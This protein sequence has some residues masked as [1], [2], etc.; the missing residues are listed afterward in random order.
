MK[1]ILLP[2]LILIAVFSKADAQLL[3]ASDSVPVRVSYF[4]VEQNS[5]KVLLNWKVVCYLRFAD[6]EVQRSTN[7]TDYTTIN[8]FTADRIR[9]LSPFNLEDKTAAGRVYYRLKVGD[10]DGNFSTSKVLVTFGREKSFE[11]NSIT[12]SLITNNTLI[13]ISSAENDKADISI[14]NMQGYTVKRLTTN[15]NKGTTDIN[16]DVS[17]LFKGIYIIRVKNSFSDFRVKRITKL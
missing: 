12:P 8:N 11:V 15:L 2:A 1:N 17:A 3:I 4:N 7:G 9:C 13:S 5:K 16:L 6:F 14:I 10:K